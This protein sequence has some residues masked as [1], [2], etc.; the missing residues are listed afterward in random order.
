M[1]ARKTRTAHALAWTALPLL[2]LCALPRPAA[3]L[4]VGLELELG[5]GIPL[6]SFPDGVPVSVDDPAG[7]IFAKLPNSAYNML[8]D[9]NPT[10]GFSS[11]LSLLLG[12]WYFR[13]ALSVNTYRDVSVSRYAFRRINGQDLAPALQN[14]YVGKVDQ[15]MSIDRTAT[16][17]ISRFGVG[18]RWYLLFETPVRPYIMMGLGGVVASIEDGVRGGMTFHGGLGA[19][20]HLHERFDLGLKL[21]YEWM[22]M[23]LPDNFQA[24]SAA[25]AIGAAA[26]SENSVLEA[27]IE[28]LH[29]L[30]LGVTATYRF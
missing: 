1:H 23:F 20:V 25:T 7:E 18:R 9:A 2:A 16:F 21:V 30:Q 24:T 28:S 12:H 5:T 22:G 4:P 10:A 14:I 26:S 3:A 6:G 27:F 19:D 11:G 8:L 29:T 13:A 15:E 17:V